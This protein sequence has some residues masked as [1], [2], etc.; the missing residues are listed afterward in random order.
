MT[1]SPPAVGSP[2]AAAEEGVP[3]LAA[4]QFNIVTADFNEA[5]AATPPYAAPIVA[6]PEAAEEE[7][8]EEEAPPMPEVSGLDALVGSFFTAEQQQAAFNFFHH[9][10]VTDVLVLLEVPDL[11]DAFVQVLNLS[12]TFHCLITHRLHK[13]AAQRAGRQ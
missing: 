2:V 9:G 5:P 12:A 13:I 11:F 6:A 3:A 7:A 1:S 4:A 10:G 8:A